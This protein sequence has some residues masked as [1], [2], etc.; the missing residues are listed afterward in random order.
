MAYP[1]DQLPTVLEEVARLLPAA[2]LSTSVRG[3][4]APGADV[5]VWSVVVLALWAVG[6]P[7]VAARVF[8]W[9]E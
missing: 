1:L 2:A 4:L 7:V 8:R 6:A 9:E 3:A 5:P